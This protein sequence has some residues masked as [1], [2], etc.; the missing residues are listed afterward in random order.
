[1]LT[2]LFATR[3]GAH[4]LPQ[5][6]EAYA[7]LREPAGGWKLVIVDNGSDDGTRECLAAYAGRLPLTYVSEPRP[8]K[9]AAL[10]TGLAATAGDLVVLTDDDVYPGPGWLVALRDAADAHPDYAVFGGVI[11]PRWEAPPEPWILSW[12]R[13]GPVYSLS[14]ELPE[15]EMPPYYV[16]GPNMAVR[17]SVFAAGGGHRFDESIGPRGGDY[18][19]G[20]ETEFVQ[21][22]HAAG[23]RAWHCRAAVVEHFIRR[24][25]LQRGWILQRAVRYGRGQQR[26]GAA[27]V[28]T[29]AR[30][31]F[32]VPRYFFRELLGDGVAAV[33]ARLR[34]DPHRTFQ[35][36]WQLSY[37]W[38][39][40]REAFLLGRGR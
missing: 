9:N 36:D 19:M 30:R 5:V 14:P 28:P 10:N 8:G 22:L 29:D 16:F 31:W 20:S 2:V 24:H 39:R 23:F 35:A 37:D 21:R 38:G 3:N 4:I 26:L 27:D 33:A 25:Q 15:G 12:V 1:M 18:P 32:G 17:A 13:L 6:L 40:V 7:R 11:V 34:G